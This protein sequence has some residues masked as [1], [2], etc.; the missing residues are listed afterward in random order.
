MLAKRKDIKNVGP[1]LL[2]HTFS[3]SD[4]PFN[5]IKRGLMYTDVNTGMPAAAVL[6][7][8]KLKTIGSYYRSE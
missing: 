6:L 4:L 7:N 1:F 2:L 3:N 5:L 8:V